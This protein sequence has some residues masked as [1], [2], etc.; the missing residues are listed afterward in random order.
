VNPDTNGEVNSGLAPGH[1][2]DPLPPS[3]WVIRVAK[4]S[5]YGFNLRALSIV[6]MHYVRVFSAFEATHSSVSTRSR[7]LRK[8]FTVAVEWMGRD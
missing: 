6:E 5:K 8:S 7:L 3:E 2:G 1:K 4:T